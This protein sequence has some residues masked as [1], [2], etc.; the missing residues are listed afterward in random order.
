MA[1]DTSTETAPE[2]A[3]AEA[4]SDHPAAAKLRDRF[5]G[6]IHEVVDA[7]GQTSV[8]SEKGRI[9]DILSFLKEEPEL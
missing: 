7:H 6:E 2:P 1:E 4:V 8:V 3:P 5:E 9:K